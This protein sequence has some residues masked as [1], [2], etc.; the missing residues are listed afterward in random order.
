MPVINVLTGAPAT[1][2]PARL[3]PVAPVGTDFT[4]EVVIGE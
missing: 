4:P 2:E 1:N 3:R